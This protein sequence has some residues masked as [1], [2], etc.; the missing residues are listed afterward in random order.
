MA[1]LHNEPID[2]YFSFFMEEYYKGTIIFRGI[3]IFPLYEYTDRDLIRL[4]DGGRILKRYKVI[5]DEERHEIR[6]YIEP[7]TRKEI[8]SVDSL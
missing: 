8:S 6:A 4:I 1:S 5:R 3:P 7:Y 2:K